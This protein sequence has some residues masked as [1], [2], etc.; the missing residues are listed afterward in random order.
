MQESDKKPTENERPRGRHAAAKIEESAATAPDPVEA[1]KP[2]TSE[3]TE[4]EDALSEE[5]LNGN[6]RLGDRV[7]AEVEDDRLRFD[8]V[9]AELPALEAAP[10]E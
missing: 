2:S 10:V 6:V 1:P 4:T 7:R 9:P 3:A 8:V 5:I